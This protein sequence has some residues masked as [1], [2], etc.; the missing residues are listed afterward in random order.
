MKRFFTDENDFNQF[1]I[2][3]KPKEIWLDEFMVDE[4][5][6]IFSF[7]NGVKFRGVYNHQCLLSGDNSNFTWLYKSGM[8]IKH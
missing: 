4:P 2:S 3:E 7:N 6:I 8:Y 5:Y 1:M